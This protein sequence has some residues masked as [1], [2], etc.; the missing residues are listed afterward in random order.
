MFSCVE[1]TSMLCILQN[2]TLLYMYDLSL[3]EC[4]MFTLVVIVCVCER[5][6][7]GERESVQKGSHHEPIDQSCILCLTLPGLLSKEPT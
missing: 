4:L 1:E 2:T 6:S 7:E 5:E 3:T